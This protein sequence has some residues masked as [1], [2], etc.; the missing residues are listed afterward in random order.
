MPEAFTVAGLALDH[1]YIGLL[2][3]SNRSVSVGFDV[4]DALGGQKLPIPSSAFHSGYRLN[5]QNEPLLCAVQLERAG[6]FD[7]V[8]SVV[9][10]EQEA[11]DLR[12][13]PVLRS[14]MLRD[15]TALIRALRCSADTSD[16]AHATTTPLPIAD[17]WLLAALWCRLQSD[18]ATPALLEPTRGR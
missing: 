7:R 15:E 4:L 12:L 10:Q 11:D 14:E 17:P 13:L 18:E 6:R 3:A 9:T 16:H 1:G 8:R 5:A 2:D